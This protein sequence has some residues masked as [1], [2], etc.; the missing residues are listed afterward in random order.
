MNYLP[1]KQSR[2]LVRVSVDTSKFPGELPSK[3]FKP[4]SFITGSQVPFNHINNTY[5]CF[6]NL[7]FTNQNKL[8]LVKSIITIYFITLTLLESNRT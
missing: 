7:L 5:Y 3:M 6:S 2:L 8:P 4:I 1:V